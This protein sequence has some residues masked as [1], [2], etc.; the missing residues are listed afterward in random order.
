MKD[1]LRTAPITRHLDRGA[2]ALGALV[3]P[4]LPRGLFARSLIII[5]A[6]VLLSL[7]AMTYVFTERHS[8]LV[9]R[10]LSAGVAGEIKLVANLTERATN[11]EERNAVFRDIEAAQDIDLTFMPGATLPPQATVPRISF[12]WRIIDRELEIVGKPIWF[13]TKPPEWPSHVRVLVQLP[14]GV[15]QFKIRRSRVLATNWHIFLVWII[16]ISSILMAIAI[17]FLRN[18]IR[19]IQRLALAAQNFGMGRDLPDFK[20]S[21]ATEV[22]Q[23]A[24][25]LIGMRNRMK[26][27][28]EQRT[29]MLAGVSHDLRT[30]LTRLKLQL[31]ML[32]SSG[33]IEDM[34]SDI[35]EMEHMLD[36]Y[37][38]FAK[39]EEHEQTSEFGLSDLMDEIGADFQRNGHT[40]DIHHTDEIA[41][42][43]KRLA[44]KRCI[45]N[46]VA[47]AFAHGTLVKANLRRTSTNWVEI[48][49]D[50]DGPGIPPE[51]YQE[52]VKPFHRL[53]QG[54]NL[55][56]GGTGLGLT[57]ANDIA[58]GHGGQLRLERSPLGGLRAIVRLPL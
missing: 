7:I 47:N 42:S 5:I 29:E 58:R 17:I 30:P 2:R 26:R 39:G 8:Q 57:I 45:S 32:Q 46:L 34:K 36:D 55:E 43:A 56:Q 3:K 9:T 52:A 31:A 44:L 19:P 6:P 51:E 50:D 41:I 11:T 14:D 25:S 16:G 24:I 35:A 22:R 53:D 27:H 33:E 54:R 1:L 20:P 48:I 18:Q 37:L 12:L 23:A 15:L 4:Y 21:G 10:R 38:A 40:I 13:H 28:I 49:I